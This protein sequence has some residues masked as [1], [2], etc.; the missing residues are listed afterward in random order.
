M[1]TNRS[2]LVGNVQA[3]LARQGQSLP[4]LR[5]ESGDLGIQ[6]VMTGERAQKR[7]R[8]D[9]NMPMF[10]DFER[11]E[12]TNDTVLTALNQLGLPKG[13]SGVISLINNRLDE[14]AVRGLLD[15]LLKHPLISIKLKINYLSYKVSP[16]RVLTYVE[17]SQS[18]LFDPEDEAAQ[19]LC[20]HCGS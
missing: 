3:S 10:W 12:L 18:K 9:P 2:L 17:G 7:Q 8:T 5:V 1:F 16:A 15:Y 14:A 11:K 19:P 6:V 20:L 4:L 13:A